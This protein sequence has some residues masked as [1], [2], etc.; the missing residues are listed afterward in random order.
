[1]GLVKPVQDPKEE[2]RALVDGE[3][4][5]GLPTAYDFH[6]ICYEYLSGLSHKK[7]EKAL[8]NGTMY[9]DCMAAIRN[10]KDTTLRTP[11]FRYWA[12]KTF[13]VTPYHKDMILTTID[14][15]PVAARERI[16]GVLK[17]CH[18]ASQ[19][20]GRDKT[21]AEVRKFYAWIPKEIVAKYVQKCP[22]C[23]SKRTLSS[24]SLG[25]MSDSQRFLVA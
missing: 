5:R 25:P 11:Q 2:A 15:K 10:P 21:S 16:L 18:L 8:L 7:R 20:G 4:D 12:R 19:H 3:T 17:H 14:G 9:H 6:L 13:R 24:A 22:T 1:M 23:Q